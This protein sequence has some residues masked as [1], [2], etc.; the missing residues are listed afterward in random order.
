MKEGVIGDVHGAAAIE[1]GGGELRLLQERVA[2]R[3]AE[4]FRG[5]RR[6]VDETAHVLH[7]GRIERAL[8]RDPPTIAMSSA[9]AAAI[10]ENRPT[11]L[12]CRRD[13]AARLRQARIRAH[14]F[15]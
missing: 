10:I 3:F 4:Q 11:M 15:A 2:L 9:G 8:K 1:I 13:A 7:E 14:D 6:R 5:F 12:K